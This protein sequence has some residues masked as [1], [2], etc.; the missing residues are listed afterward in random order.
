[1]KTGQEQ[2]PEQGLELTD[3]ETSIFYCASLHTQYTSC[4]IL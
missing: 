2:E 4:S 1:M 3:K